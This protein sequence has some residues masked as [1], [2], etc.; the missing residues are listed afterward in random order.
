MKVRNIISGKGSAVTTIRPEAAIS[1]VVRR[2]KLEGIG[3]LVEMG[4]A[5]GR[6]TWLL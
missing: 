4:A 3:A 2:L 5:K 6:R 1:T